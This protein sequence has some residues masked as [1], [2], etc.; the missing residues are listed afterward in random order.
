MYARYM[1]DVYNMHTH[2]LHRETVTY[3][4]E[5]CMQDVYN[6]Y[7]HILTPLKAVTY[8]CEVCMQ[9]VYNMY[10]HCLHIAYT[11]KQ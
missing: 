1:Q 4:C 3:L 6:M 10:T 2:C 11:A 5:V 9:D 7:T 8:L